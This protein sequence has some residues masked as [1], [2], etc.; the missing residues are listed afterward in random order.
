MSSSVHNSD[1]DTIISA[2][3]IGQGSNGL[4]I[5]NKSHSLTSLNGE[6]AILNL[7][8]ISFLLLVAVL[9]T[10]GNTCV[11]YVYRARFRKNSGSYFIMALAILDLLN[12]ALCLPWEI[13]ILSNPYNNDFPIIICKV[14][15]FL[16]TVVYL[17]A[18]LTLVCV[19]FSRFFKISH[20][21]R[22]FSS[23][24]AQSI[25]FVMVCLALAVSWP[26][27]PLSGTRTVATR[28]FGVYGHDCAISDELS[29]SLYATLFQGSL[30][31]L[32]SVCFLLMLLFYVRLILIVW[33][34]GRRRG[35]GRQVAARDYTPR[36]SASVTSDRSFGSS[37]NLS[38]TTSARRRSSGFTVLGQI[39]RTTRMLVLVTF[40]FLMGYLPL[41][42]VNVLALNVNHLPPTSTLSYGQ[43]MT[44]ELCSRSHF[45]SSAA[46]PL[47]YSV[48]NVRFRQESMIALRHVILRLPHW[49]R[50]RFKGQHGVT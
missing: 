6:Q 38:H 9:G 36:S 26:Q 1:S 7:P 19:A 37:Q 44:F 25:T 40:M 13:Y 3:D 30:H 20:P 29:E 50:R 47:I 31:V 49:L 17:S 4:L 34:R 23:R 5:S 43:R 15:R 2:R 41:I 48:L 22:C 18:A 32:L 14:A 12:S 21:L 35:L 42:T 46:N 11:V 10:A 28:V 39:G 27:I 45:L 24:R 16:V 8:I 33:V